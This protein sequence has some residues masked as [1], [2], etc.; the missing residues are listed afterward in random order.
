MQIT[1]ETNNHD[2]TVNHHGADN[3]HQQE[4][5]LT[6]LNFQIGDRRA[7][8][9]LLLVVGLRKKQSLAEWSK[10]WNIRHVFWKVFR[11]KANY[12]FCYFF[13]CLWLSASC[14]AATLEQIF[15]NV[16]FS[17]WFWWS[18]LLSL[19]KLFLTKIKM[20]FS[21]RWL[22]WSASVNFFHSVWSWS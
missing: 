7:W 20:V 4:P 16:A 19:S 8:A 12:A 14:L 15:V 6:S 3:L 11:A 18:I 1:A 22:V 9:Q 2:W 21:W 13:T 17:W 10:K 5:T